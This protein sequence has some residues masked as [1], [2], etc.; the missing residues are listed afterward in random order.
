MHSTST[1]T[2]RKPAI[3]ERLMNFLSYVRSLLFTDLLIY[4]YTAVCGTAS[5]CGSLFDSQGRWQHGCARVWS[6]LILMT[7]R[8]RL[9]IEGAE[10]IHPEKT[11]IFCSNHPSAM[12][13]PIMFVALPEQFRFLAKRSLFLV[14]FLGWHLRRSG[15]IPVERGAPREAL[16][17]FEQAALK[18][19][20]G[21]SVVMF[22]EG[23][24]SR[25]NEMLPFKAGSFYLAVRSGVPIVPITLN[26]TRAILK[27]DSLHIRAGRA[28]V[29][30]HPEIPTQGLTAEDVAAL[31]ERVRQQIVSRFK[32]DAE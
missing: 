22:P 30:I 6:K 8:I 1:M 32:P 23:R 26:G 11:V 3:G 24:R 28:E 13:I 16:K 4:T 18:I 21:R 9:H 27:P 25:T 5:I 31:A 19:R 7:S 29:I 12:D 15:H 2:A 14:P 20:E 17:G 10:N